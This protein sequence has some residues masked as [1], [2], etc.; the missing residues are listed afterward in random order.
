MKLKALIV[1]MIAAVSLVFAGTA[2]S[3]NYSTTSSERA[4]MTALIYKTFGTGWQGKTMLCIAKRESGLNPRAINYKD[5]HPTSEGTFKYSLGLFQIGALHAQHSRG[6]ARQITGGN[7][8]K[9]LDPK[10]NVA[11]AKKLAGG[12][13]GPWGGRC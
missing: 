1:T 6:V 13:L 5:S 11:V 12:G 10:I 7:K 9:L 2:Q 4:Q 8:Y 3:D